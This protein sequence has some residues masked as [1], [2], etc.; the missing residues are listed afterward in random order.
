MRAAVALP[1]V[2]V[3]AGV[4]AERAV[5]DVLV[6]HVVWH[7]VQLPALLAS[8]LPLLL[9]LL[10]P[11]WLLLQYLP[12]LHLQQGDSHELQEPCLLWYEHDL[13]LLP[14]DLAHQLPGHQPCLPPL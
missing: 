9:A 13:K 1:V 14:H 4:P 7:V 2:H 6:A 12:A 8:V 5:A 3:V 10:L 11:A